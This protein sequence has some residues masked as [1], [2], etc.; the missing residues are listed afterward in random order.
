M[1]QWFNLEVKSWCSMCHGATDSLQQLPH[2]ASPI[3]RRIRKD[4]SERLSGFCKGGECPGLSAA[5]DVLL[6]GK[7]TARESRLSLLAREAGSA[8]SADLEPIQPEDSVWLTALFNLSFYL[9]AFLVILV[10]QRPS[11]SYL[12]SPPVLLA[13]LAWL[14]LF[15]LV[16]ALKGNKKLF[17]AENKVPLLRGLACVLLAF[18]LPLGISYALGAGFYGAFL[19]W[20]V[21]MWLGGIPLFSLETYRSKS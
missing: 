15:G 1:S 7:W 11:A 2:D 18:G 21:M 13:L 10:G 4:L 20:L 8:E 16:L 3:G 6:A 9:F 5:F 19:F 12:L 17:R 14:F